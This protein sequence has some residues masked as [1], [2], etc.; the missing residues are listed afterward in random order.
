MST[1]CGRCDKTVYPTETLKCLD[2]VSLCSMYRVSPQKTCLSPIKKSL[3]LKIITCLGPAQQE[4]FYE[5]K[6]RFWD[7]LYW[8]KQT[9]ME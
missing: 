2:K 5:T 6:A 7:I 1:K 9:T 8:Q 4:L 3:A